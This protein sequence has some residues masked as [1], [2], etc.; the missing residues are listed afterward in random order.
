M[1]SPACS[2]FQL[3]L[4]REDGALEQ[5]N[6]AVVTTNFFR[7]LGGGI[8]YG[9]DFNDEDAVPN[10]PPPP[11]GSQQQGTAPARLPV[12]AILSNE[13][14]QRR[15]GGDASVIGRPA[16]VAGAQGPTPIIIGVI[17]PHFQLYFPPETQVLPAPD[18]WI[19]NRL[20]YNANSRNNVSIH[21]VGRL[22]PG[23]TPLQA[24]AD[25]EK[26]AAWER[27]QFPIMG[28]G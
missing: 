10:P 13:Y 6:A 8:A 2:L 1:I 16:S 5:A 22:R 20:G 28:D 27:A 4:Q 7:L 12:Y 23:V 21:A 9:R 18:I 26:V 14:F 11:P 17:A 19:A 15:Y 24:Q 25:S 3:T